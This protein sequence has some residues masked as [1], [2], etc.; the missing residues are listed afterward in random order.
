MPAV[1]IQKGR[2]NITGREKPERGRRW[3][4]GDRSGPANPTSYLHPQLILAPALRGQISI[5][6]RNDPASRPCGRSRSWLIKM[7]WAADPRVPFRRVEHWPW[8]LYLIDQP[9]W[10]E[11]KVLFL[12]GGL[13]P[14]PLL[15]FTEK[16]LGER[17]SKSYVFFSVCI[18]LTSEYRQLETTKLLHEESHVSY[19][20]KIMRF[21]SKYNQ[22]EHI[23]TSKP[24]TNKSLM[25]A[26]GWNVLHEFECR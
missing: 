18:T 10:G 25:E 20:L 16:S 21:T 15:N 26:T 8:D 3:D 19:L 17:M 1:G 13:L 14:T 23:Y 22:T 9:V 11:K 5:C 12:Q 24:A 6:G 4:T 7:K 2:K